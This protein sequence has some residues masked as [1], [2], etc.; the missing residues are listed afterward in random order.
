MVSSQ[1]CKYIYTENG[2]LGSF[3]QT[4]PTALLRVTALYATEY[5]GASIR[6]PTSR[7]RL[8]T[9]AI[10]TARARRKMYPVSSPV[11][12]YGPQGRTQLPGLERL[13]VRTSESCASHC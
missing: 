3:A 8:P 7:Y 6:G 1:L 10:N 12:L 13:S 2:R 11:D 9:L 5:F 4:P